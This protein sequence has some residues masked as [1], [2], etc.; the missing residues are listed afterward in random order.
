MPLRMEGESRKKCEGYCSDEALYLF[1][2]VCDKALLSLTEP[3]Y[4]SGFFDCSSHYSISVLLDS[5]LIKHKN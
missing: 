1:H 2:E 5:I 3:Y 4:S